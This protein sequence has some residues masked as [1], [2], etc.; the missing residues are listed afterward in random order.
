MFGSVKEREFQEL[1]NAYSV[2]IKYHEGRGEKRQKIVSAAYA[3]LVD[4]T[5]KNPEFEK[6]RPPLIK[7]YDDNCNGLQVAVR[8]LWRNRLL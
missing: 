8:D 6:R 2:T 7:V 4:F 3:Q 5:N 1:I